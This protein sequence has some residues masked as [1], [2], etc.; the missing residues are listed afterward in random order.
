MTRTTQSRGRE[1]PRLVFIDRGDPEWDVMW[2]RL[3]QIFGDPVCEDPDTGEVWQYMGTVERPGG[4]WRHEFRHRS[5]PWPLLRRL[6]HHG[7][8]LALS[9]S[10][11][12]QYLHLHASEGWAP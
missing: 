11:R 7:M 1:R 2:S 4:G 6:H 9:P 10:E 5:I 3:T 12:R 8:A